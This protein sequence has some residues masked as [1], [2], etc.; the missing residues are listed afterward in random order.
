M[1]NIQFNVG[2]SFDKTGAPTK[3]L[4]LDNI[5]V[6]ANCTKEQQ[7]FIQ[8]YNSGYRVSSMT[9]DMD[10]SFWNGCV[11]IDV[12]SKHYYNDVRKFNEDRL[13][14]ELHSALWS[15]YPYNYYA[16][17][18]SWSGTS[19][20]I[21]FYYNVDKTEENIRK[22]TQKSREYVVSVF[23]AIGRG[24]VIHYAGV[25]DK[26]T[27]SPY[28]GIFVSN[29]DIKFGMVDT[30]D[31][32]D[33]VGDIDNYELQT[34]S[35]IHKADDVDASGN[36]MFSVSGSISLTDKIGIEH[37]KRMALYLT[38]CAAYKEKAVVDG[39]Y[40]DMMQHVASSHN[41]QFLV[42]EP[43]NNRWFDKQDIYKHMVD[44]GLLTLFGLDI[45]RVFAPVHVDMY[46]ADAVYTLE[47]GQHISD[48]D[49]IKFDTERI[50]HVYAGCGT[51]KTYWAKHLGK[52]S[53]V[54]FVSPLTSI[55]SDSFS[56]VNGWMV[57]DNKFKDIAEHVMPI[58][59]LLVS[60]WNI[61]TTWESFCNY[62]M[63]E[64]NFD[65]VIVDEIHSLY[66]YDYRLGS[67]ARL[68]DA[69]PKA[70]GIKIVMTGTPSN[71]VTELGTYNIKIEK[72]Q[73][74]IDSEV[75][76]YNKSYMGWIYKD[77]K[78]WTGKSSD[79]YAI[80]FKDTF[81]YIDEMK[82]NNEGIDVGMFNSRYEDD[83]QSIID[84]NNVTKQVTLFSVYGQAGINLYI[85]TEKRLRLYILSNNALGIIQYANRVRNKEVIDKVV[86]PYKRENVSSSVMDVDLDVDIA[87]AESRVASLN[88][89]DK[90]FKESIER[91]DVMSVL[92]TKSILKLRYGFVPET[93]DWNGD[94]LELNK[95]NY[96]NW[97]MIK[98][99][100][101]YEKQLQ[102]IY[103]RLVDNYFNVKL[104]YLDEDEKTLKGTKLR[105][106]RLAGQLLNVGSDVIH[107]DKT[108]R[109]YIVPTT[110][111]K[112]Y[113]TGDLKDSIEYI[114]NSMYEG[115]IKMLADK[116]NRMMQ[117]LIG[118]FDTLKK[119]HIDDLALVYKYIANWNMYY[120]NA[121]LYKMLDEAAD[122][123]LIA[124]AYM[125]SRLGSELDMTTKEWQSLLEE[126]YDKTKS[127]R[128]TVMCYKQVFEDLY[129]ESGV[130]P[131]DV[132]NDKMMSMFYWHLKEKHT[133]WKSGGK[134]G[135]KAGKEI[136]IDGVTYKTKKEAAEALGISRQML[137][138]RLKSKI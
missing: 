74:M 66:M 112:K 138:R 109:V 9:K 4:S 94:V 64:C 108:S 10:W 115:D 85:D 114:L 100:T 95:V 104:T 40:R 133:R 111:M 12:D 54:C 106:N 3:V 32:G 71:E 46:K 107:I 93:L 27:N 77:I 79:N 102:I 91:A 28:Q 131:L 92:K 117:V 35:Y 41:Y 81:N 44:A 42:G 105:A 118:N 125:R 63:Y 78:E 124:A 45:S 90:K 75:V 13:L 101:E 2:S 6:P 130:E 134:I 89:L 31:F 103:N 126:A 69:L 5:K 51:G 88:K 22:C 23:E 62:K 17:Q 67:I 135:G 98:K 61:C 47:D 53:R 16:I 1:I 52:T 7:P 21:F 15:E 129:A 123:E 80:V 59:E 65:Y 8:I 50:N 39:M 37:R 137:D 55:N 119:K 128:K 132:E 24:D 113:L 76:V 84:S 36:A 72:K 121:V 43:D 136:M 25:L 11:I 34:A 58:D 56:D 30:I 20:H 127:I 18:Q 57:V 73:H 82:F 33:F 60:K 116:Y 97:Y 26:C 110:Q 68:K 99:T 120:D 14:E 96:K 122:D 86:I 87:D 29:R 70:R 19:Y 48:L 49:G 83:V 38:L